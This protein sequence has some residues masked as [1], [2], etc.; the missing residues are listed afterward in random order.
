MR[1]A[2]FVAEGRDRFGIVKDDGLIDLT[3]HIEAPSLRHALASGTDAIKPHGG[4]RIDW[5]FDQ[6][7]W[8]PTIPDPVHIVALGLNTKSHFEE[9]AE[10]MNR[11]P[12]DYPR[13]PRLF[14]RSPL[15]VVGHE[16][17]IRR[18]HVSSRLDYEG[19]IALVIG[20][21]LSV[22][23]GRGRFGIRGRRYLCERRQHSRLPTTHRPD[24]RREELPGERS[25]RAVDDD[26]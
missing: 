7:R 9:T 24:H 25:A 14:M 15:S 4:E 12:G 19:E 6:V 18:P 13:Y 20:S 1:L 3:R 10:L 2:S 23:P 5:T 26:A 17:H 22:P 8:L 11:T 21:E 16:E